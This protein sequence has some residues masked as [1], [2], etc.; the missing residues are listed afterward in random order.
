MKIGDRVLINN[1]CKF[2]NYIGITGTIESVNNSKDTIMVNIG[3][4]MNF[5]VLIEWVDLA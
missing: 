3:R 1:K 4:W 5:E 2:K